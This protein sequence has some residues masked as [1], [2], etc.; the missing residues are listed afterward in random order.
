MKVFFSTMCLGI[1]IG[2]FFI[3]FN[4][5]FPSERNRRMLSVGLILKKQK[6]QIV[7]IHT[8]GGVQVPIYIKLCSTK[9]IFVT[10]KYNITT[11]DNTKKL[12]TSPLYIVDMQEK[13]KEADY[14]IKKM[15]VNPINGTL[16]HVTESL[17]II[18]GM[19]TTTNFR[20]DD[21]IITNTT[22]NRGHTNTIKKW[23]G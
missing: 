5:V 23:K 9:H 19:E 6:R 21:C 16:K 8:Q 1:N 20:Q 12:V 10:Q 7:T 14:I 3:N 18:D 13:R 17:Q 4:L 11:E 15:H 22:I 2:R